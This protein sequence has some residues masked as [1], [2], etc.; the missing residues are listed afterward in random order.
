[1]IFRGLWRLFRLARAA[2]A[3]L[4]LSACMFGCG[5]ARHDEE[6]VLTFPGTAVGK[7]AQ[8]L[9]RQIERFTWAHPGVRVVH[10]LTPDSADERHQLYVQWLNAQASDPDLLQLDVIWTPEFAAAGW[11]LPLDGFTPDTR[12]FFDA[13]VSA[14]RF[15]NRLYALPWFVDVGMLYFRSDL[16]EKPESLEELVE[17]AKKA[18][19]EHGLSYG[20]V[21]QGARY[22]GLICVF[23]ELLGAFGGGILDE[24][25]RV[26]VDSAEALRALKFLRSTLDDT[27]PRA[28]L[29]WREEQAR[30]AFQNGQAAFMRNWPYAWALLEDETQSRVAGRFQVASMPRAKN[31]APSA[32]LGGA[33]LAI[34]AKTEHPAQAFELIQFLAAPE[35]MLERA[36][37]LGQLPARYDLYADPRLSRALGRPA[38]PLR[39]I[40]EHARERPVTPVYAELSQILQIRLHR[41]LTDQE[42]PEAALSAAADE[43]RRTLADAGLS[44][45]ARAPLPSST[46][47]WTVRLIFIGLLAAAA[48]PLWRAWRRQRPVST[49]SG[50]ARLAWSLMAPALFVVLALALFPLG[51]ATYESLHAHDLSLPR[52]GRPFVGLQNYAALFDAPRFWGALGRTLAFTGLSVG[53]ELVLGLAIA[54][55]LDRSFRGRGIVRTIAILPWAV[56]TVVSALV[57]RLLFEDGAT[58]LSAVFAAPPSFF[59]DP[60]WAWLPLILADVWKTTPFITLLLLA[61]LQTIDPRFEE[62]ARLDGAGFVDRLLGITLPLLRPALLVAL[63]FR[64]LDAFRI[65]DLVYVLTGGGPGTATEPIALYTYSTLFGNLRFGLGSALSVVVFLVS[66]GLALAYVRLLEKPVSE[67]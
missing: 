59:S 60:L 23:V 5:P 15:E 46:S 55:L 39:E 17:R 3:W 18:R 57:F 1:M 6:I 50:E 62:A 38:A 35:Q 34:N 49:V 10:Q 30:F 63:V 29:G 33:A 42:A 12:G 20:F 64:S 16:V 24:D 52:R 65:F 19:A 31:G 54:L 8:L 14:E 67:S 41:A 56:P 32:T 53:I 61:G 45:E 21:W 11:L 40:V 37:E 26:I 22:E 2:A 9:A 27:S 51:Y 7:E 4:V 66:F 47:R 44:H 36:K 25:G 43:M 48:L 28:V 13:A 58:P